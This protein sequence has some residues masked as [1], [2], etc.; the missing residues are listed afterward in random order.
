M[1]AVTKLTGF[2]LL[3]PLAFAHFEILYP[4][5]RGFNEDSHSEWPCGGFDTVSPNRSEFP[6]SGG[7]IQIDSTHTESYLQVLLAVGNEPEESFNVILVPTLQEQGPQEFCFGSVNITPG[8]NLT[9]GSN[10]TIQ[11]ISSGHSGGLYAVC[12]SLT[13]PNPLPITSTWEK[14]KGKLKA[15]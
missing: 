11:V 15:G 12:R 14:G 10:A 5:S 13:C 2:A 4:G 9:V 1:C 3:L 8:I 7:P 6:L